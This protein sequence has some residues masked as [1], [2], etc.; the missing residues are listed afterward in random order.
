MPFGSGTSRSPDRD[1]LESAPDLY[2]KVVI[3]GV[4]ADLLRL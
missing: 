1:P 4:S 2:G 3:E